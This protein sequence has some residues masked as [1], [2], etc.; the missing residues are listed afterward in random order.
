MSER[1][2]YYEHEPLFSDNPVVRIITDYKLP[3]KDITFNPADPDAFG[4]LVVNFRTGQHWIVSETQLKKFREEHEQR[5]A[6]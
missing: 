3:L 6:S 1:K 4:R 2:N 5:R